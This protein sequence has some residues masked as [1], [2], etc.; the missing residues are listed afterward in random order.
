MGFMDKLKG[1]VSAVTGGAA[2]VTIQIGKQAVYAGDTIEVL[3]TCRSKGAEV[4]SKGVF[5]DIA[6][7]ELIRIKGDDNRDQSITS[8]T[9]SE[10]IQI[11]PAVVLGAGQA[12]EFRGTF[13]IP[14]SSPPTYHGRAVKHTVQ[15]R[16]R[17]EAFGNDPDSG[18]SPI[19]VCT[20]A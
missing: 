13:S 9:I 18:F 20:R 3:V 12:M 5:I 10:A 6:G 1:A 4:K 16:A 15:I 14:A 2:E 19:T 17:L 11:A 7:E 8:R